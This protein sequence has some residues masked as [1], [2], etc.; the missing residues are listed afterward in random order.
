MRYTR[1]L[2]FSGIENHRQDTN[3][4]TL[5]ICEGAVMG[6][7]GSVQVSPEMGTYLLFASTK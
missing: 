7:V 1:I 5:R 2:G 6:A 4:G 3:L